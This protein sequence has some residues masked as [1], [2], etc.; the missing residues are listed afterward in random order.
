MKSPVP[1]A[2][3]PEASDSSGCVTVREMKSERRPPTSNAPA[4]SPRNKRLSLLRE[5]LLL[6]QRFQNY[7]LDAVIDARRQLNRNGTELFSLQRQIVD[8]HR[9]LIQCVRIRL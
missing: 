4:P 8:L 3:T 1:K 2:R 5:F 9:F 7:K 6:S